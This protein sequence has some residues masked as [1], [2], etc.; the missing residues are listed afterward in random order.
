MEGLHRLPVDGS[1]GTEVL[2]LTLRLSDKKE[3][4]I[5]LIKIYTTGPPGYLF[6]FPTIVIHIVA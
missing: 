4:I 2:R 3:K 1:G 6:R 5:P